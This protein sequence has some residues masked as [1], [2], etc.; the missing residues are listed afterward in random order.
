MRI[1]MDN[2]WPKSDLEMMIFGHSM[3]LTH[4]GTSL[5]HHTTKNLD[6]TICTI[7]SN[8]FFL[9][10]PVPTSSDTKGGTRYKCAK[11]CDKQNTVQFKNNVRN[12][13]KTGV[14]ECSIWRNFRMIDGRSAQEKSTSL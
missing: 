14:E 6:A 7:A 4:M 10:F 12:A 2:T 3:L 13:C 9:F 5:S 8:G 11:I 1:K